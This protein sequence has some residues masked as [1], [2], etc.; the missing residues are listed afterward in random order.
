M[1]ME[2]FVLV[3]EA[4]A[5]A[6]ALAELDGA[7]LIGVDVE[8]ADWDRYW[9]TAALIQVGSAGRVV[10]VDPLKLDD[11]SPLAAFLDGR[12]TVLHAMSNDLAPLAS[13]GVRLGRVEDTAIAAELLGLPTG[14]ETLLEELLGITLA[15]DKQVMQRAAWEQRPLRPEMLAY[16]AGDVAHLPALW[17]ELRARLLA[18]G[19][20]DWYREQRD[21]LR[22]QPELEERRA[23]TNL[24]GI[25]TLDA[26]ARGRARAL[27][28]T[29]ERLARE[30][31]TAP[32]R[33][34]SDKTL[35]ELAVTPVASAHELPR[36]GMRR[37]SARR[38]GKQ[39][40]S[41]LGRPVVEEPPPR[42]GRRPTQADRQAADKLRSLRAARAKA[43]GLDPGVLCPSRVLLPA[44]LADPATPAALSA[45]L[46]LRDWQWQILGYDFCDALGL[47]TARMSPFTPPDPRAEKKGET[48]G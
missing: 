6:D 47:D 16:A 27:W 19:R 12:V 40:L 8:R 23:W 30:H 33:I 37:Q 35:V 18:V 31:D 34:I 5:L 42:G 17:D 1:P 26:L 20:L 48:D 43:L 22:E 44:V 25:G 10:L 13:A 15:G 41:G 32:G 9:R 39:L 21:A 7:P 2:A 45:A 14:L 46:H 29:R 24:K 11:L 28:E 36:R 4:D 38:F 3:E